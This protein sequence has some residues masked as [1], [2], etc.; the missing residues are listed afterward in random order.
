MV[1][2][3]GFVRSDVDQAV[4]YRRRGSSLMV[5]LV[6]V[7]DCS[8]V[9]TALPL[10]KNF[11]IQIAKHVEITDLGEIHWILGIEVRRIRER[12]R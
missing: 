8:L 1:D 7:D 3:L 5:V 2:G 10:I 12:C 9:A 4:F 11:K 6:H